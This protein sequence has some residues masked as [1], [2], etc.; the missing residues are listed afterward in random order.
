MI[1]R[2]W[3]ILNLLVLSVMSTPAKPEAFQTSR[4][5][6]HQLPGGK[7]AD[8]IE[9]DFI[10]RNDKVEVVISQ[11][12]YRRKANMTTF[13]GGPEAS[14]PG[15]LYDLTLRGANNDQITIFAPLKRR[16]AVSYV[17]VVK[18]GSDG[19][20]LIETVAD[21]AVNKGLYERHTYALKDGMQGVLITTMLRNETDKPVDRP[22][23]DR[24]TSFTRH[25]E[26][27]GITWFNA[28][29]PAPRVGY[30][31][32]HLETGD[33]NKPPPTLTLKPGVSQAF[34][35]FLAIAE[36]PAHAIGLVLE[37]QGRGGRIQGT[38]L[39]KP[40][41]PV[42]SAEIQLTDSGTQNAKAVPAYTD[43]NGA[44]G[45][46]FPEGD[47]KVLIKDAGRGTLQ[48]TL[49]V[50]AGETT[51]LNKNLPAP[52]VLQFDITNDNGKSLPCKAQIIGIKGTASPNLGPPQRAH[53]CM[54]QYHSEKGQ[55]RVEV[56][57]GDYRV[58]VTR[59][60]EYA[61]HAEDVHLKAGQAVP[62]KA[63]LKHV[64]DT[65]GWISA[66]FHNHS[67]PSGD[68]T[69]GTDDRV[70]NLAAEHIEFAPTTEHNRLYDW[71]PH[72]Q[73][74][75]LGDHLYTVGG[76]ELTGGGAHF[77]AFPLKGDRFLQDGG[78]PE[79]NKDPRISAILLREFQ[80]PNPD[81]WVQLNHPDMSWMFFDR[82]RDGRGDGGYIGLGQLIDGLETQ[83]GNSMHILAD[84]PYLLK[85]NWKGVE[86]V[87][88]CREFLWRQLL[89]Q[90]HRIWAVAVSD[91]HYVHGNGVGGWRCYLPS[92]SDEPAR[93]QWR[94]L[95]R[96]AKAGRM[97]LSNGPFL[98]VETEDGILPG[99][100]A[101]A[102]RV[103]QLKVRVQCT[104]WINIDRVQVLVNGAAIETLN[105]TRASHPTWFGNGVVKFDRTLEI[106]LARDSHII[107]VAYGETHTLKTGYGSSPQSRM[108]PCAYNN[109]IYIDVD[110]G[111]F[112][113]NGDTLG[114]PIPPKKLTPAE[115][116]KVLGLP[117]APTEPNKT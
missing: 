80:G 11:N 74:L 53:G 25:G 91:A 40:N 109:P 66:D 21:A 82:N 20:A 95:S 73:K 101:R 104:D 8:G 88:H 71:N 42:T 37:Q 30:A 114:H 7:E 92:S 67:S 18:D 63:K 34:A 59:G 113:P 116:R 50:K 111:G 32:G 27:K 62:V 16:G 43:P 44:F 65:R 102:N 93:F 47:Y 36:S 10:L 24:V 46:L 48:D 103:V 23:R 6:R 58:V 68:N 52:G 56:P 51:D 15:C 3:L 31:Y 85:K 69:C 106:N 60:I 96:H 112:T 29:D 4:P 22:T 100:L 110:G 75:G 54:D 55:F 105:Y 77:N 87:A 5:N 49:Q 108:N 9:G 90:G 97:V 14:S 33:L 61:H 117:E 35:R 89:N 115:A 19:E 17:R 81:R 28:V 83:N 57:P 79:W 78:A 41:M 13:W 39:E 86:T 94:E 26:L 70:I 38:L 12:A 64:V 99:G 98:T 107:V 72:I 2:A 76:I 45:F 84:T 1:L